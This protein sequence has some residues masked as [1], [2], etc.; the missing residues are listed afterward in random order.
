MH[1]PEPVLKRSGLGSG[2]CPKGERMNL[3]QRKVPEGEAHA[4]AQLTL[5][6][7]DFPE[8]VSGVRALIVAVLDDETTGRRA[9]HVVHPAVKRHH[10][11]VGPIRHPVSI[12]PNDGRR[13]RRR[14]Y[15]PLP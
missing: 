14:G 4:L 15:K 1:L 8:R 5:H 11:C 6:A 7:L 12:L 3:R 13:R 2:R 10:A 9:A